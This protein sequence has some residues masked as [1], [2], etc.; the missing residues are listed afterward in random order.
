MRTVLKWTGLVV[1]SLVALLVLAAGVLY[2]KGSS[3]IAQT[4]DV[5]VAALSIPTDSAAVAR[6]RHLADIYGCRDCHG[7]DLSGQVMAD[8]GPF[9]LVAANLTPAGAGAAYTD[10]AAWDRAI[11]HGVGADGTALVVMPSGAYHGVSDR[12]AA[13]LI[14]YL[15]ALAPIENDL[16]P[17]QWYALGKVLAGGPMDPSS[18][19]HAEPTP[20]DSPPAGATRAY[21]AYVAGM[22]C[23]YCHGEGLVGAQP[24]DPASPYAPDLAAAG[25]WPPE[26]FHRALTTGVAADGRQ[27]DPM[28][29]PW[30]STARMTRDEREGIRLYL[31]TLAERR[32]T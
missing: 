9:R 13:D 20:A 8:E 16:P 6:G 28:M 21:G 17:M 15:Q 31:A 4:Y 18:A 30:T 19:V 5:P 32:G 29:M 26:T 3:S 10:A 24:D 14:A 7:A 27:M 12:E 25:Q 11:R 22:M 2:A 23:A 1:G